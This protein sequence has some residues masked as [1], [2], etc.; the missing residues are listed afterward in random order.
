M[1]K[2]IYLFVIIC[3][4]VSTGFGTGDAKDKTGKIGKIMDEQVNAWNQGSF[5]G[6]MAGY[7]KSENLTFQSGN[8]RRKG[9]ET[10]L[11]MYKKNYAG[12]K[13]GHLEF[14]DIEMRVLTKE[15]VLVLGRWKV[16][17]KADAKEGLFTLIFRRIGNEWR[18][19][20][21]HSS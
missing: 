18:I 9:W 4:L 7:W 1:N 3:I 2:T 16:T 19:I 14:T 5:E 8:T 17:T 6:F 11:A 10:L 15:L 20:H 21:D 13:R 12:K